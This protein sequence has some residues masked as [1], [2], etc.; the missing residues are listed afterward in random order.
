MLSDIDRALH[1]A[2]TFGDKVVSRGA[3]IYFATEIGIN[4]HGDLAIANPSL[5]DEHC[6]LFGDSRAASNLHSAEL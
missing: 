3:P 4:H 5:D 1:M 2:V 6:I